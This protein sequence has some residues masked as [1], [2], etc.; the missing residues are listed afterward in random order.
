MKCINIVNLQAS[1]HVIVK[2]PKVLDFLKKDIATEIN[3]NY[4]IILK[5][6]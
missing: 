1:R 2:K 5:N 3:G 6:M 4:Y